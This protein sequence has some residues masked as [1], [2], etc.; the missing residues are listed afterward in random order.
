MS[1]HRRGFVTIAA[2]AVAGALAPSSAQGAAPRSL[3]VVL[4]PARHF[5]IPLSALERFRVEREEY[6]RQ[7]ERYHPSPAPEGQRPASPWDSLEAEERRH[8]EADGE[9]EPAETP[10]AEGPIAAS[11]E[12]NPPR[13][14]IRTRTA[15]LGVRG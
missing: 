4:P 11:S 14:T 6:E 1:I 8:A 12:S 15:V 5:M 10:P 13:F 2:G 3:F 9:P 7:Y